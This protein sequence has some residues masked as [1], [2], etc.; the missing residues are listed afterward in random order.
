MANNSNFTLGV[1]TKVDVTDLN[2]LREQLQDIRK[3]MSDPVQTEGLGLRQIRNAITASRQLE[4]A[5]TSAYDVN[6]NTINIDKFNQSL[7]KSGT[8]L[9]E[10]QEGLSK[11]GPEGQKAFVGATT[12]LFKF[13][14]TVKQSNEFLEKMATTMGNT[15]RWS[16][17]STLLNAIV[18]SVEKA[19]YYIEDLDSG[20]NDIRIVTGK[21][22]DEMARF[23]K[24]ANDAAKALAVSTTD[25]T[26]GA[27]I[28]YQQG[29]PEE[30]VKTLTEITAK[31]SNVTGQSM[32]AVSEQLTAVWNGY[33]VANQAAEEG[34]GVYEEYVDKMAAV[35]AA[36]A[37]DLEELATAMSKVASAASSM[38]VDFDQLSAQIATIVSVTRQ[39]PE[40]VGTALKTIY[41]RIGDLKVEGIDE[42]GVSLGEVSSQ[43]KQVGI[44]VLDQSGNLRDVGTVMEEVAAKWNTWTE[45]Q[46]Q[47]V[48]IAMAG[49]R[50]YN[51][52]ISLF[53]NWNMYT[54]TLET[55]ANA[56]GTLDRQQTIALDSLEN[57]LEKLS[58]TAEDM[59]DSLIDEES[60]KDLVDLATPIVQIIADLA[61]GLGGLKSILPLV[62]GSMAKLFSPQIAKGM[63]PMVNNLQTFIGKSSKEIAAQNL[64]VELQDSIFT[65]ENSEMPQ[66]IRAELDAMT[67]YYSDMQKSSSLMTD[68][69]IEF[70]RAILKS[71]KAII[72]S[73]VEL[74]NLI[75]VTDRLELKNFLGNREIGGIIDENEIETTKVLIGKLKDKKYKTEAGFLKGANTIFG[76][77]SGDSVA[78]LYDSIYDSM[79]E[80]GAKK[81]KETAQKAIAQTIEEL[82][83]YTQNKIKQLETQREIGLR[84]SKIESDKNSLNE[85]LNT[86]KTISNITQVIGSLTQLSASI[87][88]IQNLGSIWN[89]ESISNT[90][91]F[92]QTITALGGAVLTAVPAIMSMV[93]V[94]GGPWTAAI[95]IGGLVIGGL[96]QLFDELILTAEEADEALAK[97]AAEFEEINKEYK[98]IESNIENLTEKIE[99]LE[100]I[101]ASGDFSLTDE[102][103]LERLREEKNI[104]EED[105]RLI[106]EK[107]DIEK[108]KNHENA[109]NS[110]NSK[111]T[112]KYS[113][114]ISTFYN[115]YHKQ[116][117]QRVTYHDVTRDQELQ[118]AM[119][120][121]KDAKNSEDREAIRQD[122]ADL[123]TKIKEQRDNLD[124]N[125]EE[126]AI[127]HEEL[128]AVVKEYFSWL[129]NING[130]KKEQL[131]L[132]GKISLIE[133]KTFT[134]SV[135]SAQKLKEGLDLLNE[136][137]KDIQDGGNFDYS[138]LI[139]NKDFAKIFSGTESY[140]E[141]IEIV[142][143]TPDDIQACQKAFNEL[144]TDYITN[145]KAL[146]GINEKS[147]DAIILMLQQEGIVNASEVVDYYVKQTE[148][149]N[150]L[151]K[152]KDALGIK[153]ENLEDL[154]EEEINKLF[155]EGILSE[156]AKKK[157][158]ELY[159][160]KISLNDNPLEVETSLNRLVQLAKTAG[161]TSEALVDLTE[162]M[163]QINKLQAKTMDLK[164]YQN[165]FGA[166]DNDALIKDSMKLAELQKQ[167]EDLKEQVEAD[168]K[169]AL[170]FDVSQYTG[171]QKDVNELK[172]YIDEFDRYWDIKKAIDAVTESI[173]DLNK[174]QE[175]LF[176]NE[177]IA[178]LEKENKLLEEQ[179]DKYKK[180]Y[181]MQIDEAGELQWTLQQFGV[182]F[183]AE[184]GIDNYAA[185]TQKMLNA[186]NS[187]T[188]SDEQYEKFKDALERYEEVYY[189]EIVDTQNKLT[190]IYYE[191]LANNVEAW[192]TEIELNLEF[193]EAEREWSDF[194]KEISDDFK[195]TYRDISKDFTHLFEQIGSYS[196]KDGT[197]ATDIKALNDAE[198][199]LLRIQAHGSSDMFAS[200][201]EAEERVKE[202]KQTLT[203]DVE[204]VH[205]LWVDAWDAYMEGIDQASD[206]FDD[207]MSKFDAINEELKYQ[208][209]LIE[210]L[211]GTQAY[212]LMD[213]LYDAQLNNSLA[214]VDSLR[215]QANMWEELYN[216]AEEGSEEQT[217]YYEKWQEAQ[218][219]LNDLVIEHI[220]LLKKDY[221][222][223]LDSILDNLEKS[224]T[225]GLGLD[226]M[227]ENWEE[228]TAAA[229]KYFDATERIYELE[230]LEN[231]FQTAIGES[232]ALKNQQKLK[233]LMDDQLAG[234][235]AKEK[236]TEYDI[237]LAEKRLAIAQ[238]E[239]ALE[240]AQNSKNTMKLTRGA[241][242][243][244]EYQYV[245]DESDV[246][247]KRQQTLD[248]YNDL[249]QHV[250]DTQEKSVESILTMTEQFF[251]KLNEI[252]NNDTLSEEQ[253]MFAMEELRERYYGD[254]GI[255]TVLQQEHAAYT[256]DLNKTNAEFLWGLYKEDED[257]YR[258]LTEEQKELINGFKE[259]G[260]NDYVSL[261]ETVETEDET[262][263]NKLEKVVNENMLPTWTSAAQQMAKSWNAD[264]G[265]SVKAQVENAFTQMN[266]ALNKYDESLVDLEKTSNKS[267]GEEGLKGDIENAIDETN[268]LK[269]A[270][271]AL[272]TETVDAL[273]K[274]KTSVNEIKT[275]WLNVKTAMEEVILKNKEA[276]TIELPPPE[277][278]KPSTG[279]PDIKPTYVDNGTSGGV[280]EI[281]TETNDDENHNISNI[282]DDT[283]PHVRPE[284]EVKKDVDPPFEK[285]DKIKSYESSSEN[286]GLVKGWIRTFTK[287]KNNNFTMGLL[288]YKSSGLS[289]RKIEEGP[290]RDRVMPYNY[291]KVEDVPWW[292]R[293]SQ[294]IPYDTGGYTGSWD[295]SGRVAMLHQKEL[296]LNASD[297]ENMLETVKM[298]RDIANLTSSVGSSVMSGV[299][300]L[301]FEMMG[302]KAPGGNMTMTPQVADG[303]N[304]FNITA[305]FPN[306][307]SVATI[308]EA[309]LS[310]PNL[311]SQY[312][313]ENR[314]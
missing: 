55:A 187:S 197:I 275:A 262:M 174:E 307:D 39:A 178:S 300:S 33:Q 87:Q 278:G 25:Y 201:S 31:T 149:V 244:W 219:N 246:A 36:T 234:L 295:S 189:K 44:E 228:S 183:N 57:K 303:N 184:G 161:V 132:S 142:T 283:K 2:K 116:E 75:K 171:T 61:D 110:A 253:K 80:N 230:T 263:K 169:T 222:N 168:F 163:S 206:K 194:M 211:Y 112:S 198:A 281:D 102:E 83:E 17:T 185:I 167:A 13:N 190:D 236:L 256:D 287:D 269:D 265:A 224:V 216:N 95:A 145:S 63:M 293:E 53:N 229:D 159:Y 113:K 66:Y 286:Q 94:I 212:S 85:S 155:N 118:Y 60:L 205:G 180:L 38:G 294:L 221:N 312:L 309:I 153:T 62:I 90:E 308:Q 152:A 121:Y 114:T 52:L 139:N 162:I 81:G 291:Y 3:M 28:Y 218:T 271:N 164:N 202:L 98:S 137:Y 16:I 141:F 11:I 208:G 86:Q 191:Q 276:Q 260:I 207:L 313:A 314:K 232:A 268:K 122:A 129:D 285:G 111:I 19:Y 138:N 196:E 166:I 120:A 144:T 107:N 284:D 128:N 186:Y 264:D 279:K 176:G 301:M 172:K 7:K 79:I 97:S 179:T 195:A 233:K 258:D 77:E 22:A 305:E 311:A 82:K 89:D 267:F 74:E 147:R 290:V 58:A 250:K 257:N 280:N 204:A 105:L 48:A 69:Q 156:Y 270:T 213:S 214:Q 96:I 288:P 117:M 165:I 252:R 104:L 54:D 37:S 84:E 135:A 35:G 277:T 73:K 133:E 259:Q 199:E 298:V 274:Y 239:I 150:D 9:K 70:Y 72:D 5:L 220:N 130:V 177:L 223:T 245:A 302:M 43:L 251:T 92:T 209:E 188:I 64:A 254:N 100:A 296:V 148:I 49:K 45:A 193:E 15:I 146:E 21:S 240:D 143:N 227:R 131:D 101:I 272:Y 160:V 304:V 91:K 23:A 255:I 238:A 124:I 14:K 299:K 41:A 115:S 231:K 50:Q 126:G 47:S 34:M 106:K 24:Y 127:K 210:L 99:E 8:N 181:E 125:T 261:R 289:G 215:Q 282:K 123:V 88:M 119:N 51:N 235:E 4:Q 237:S 32:Q 68:E 297:T 310:L 158:L 103:E 42:F 266:D 108:A 40:S 170:E 136:V 157:L 1:K 241:S 26:E 20:L 67:E 154:T 46:R 249:Y 173:E 59:Y 175:H 273:S 71:K 182:A 134:Q 78:K 27:L 247:E 93:S 243:N 200:V 109:M 225:G 6:L 18:G 65:D 306:A 292:F 151:K 30:T 217:K 76:D 56:A 10:I 140:Q 248:A 242:G 29:L 203:E 192:E 12:E 226:K